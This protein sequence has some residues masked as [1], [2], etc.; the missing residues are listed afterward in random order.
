[1]IKELVKDEALLSQPGEVAT[2]DDLEVVQDLIDTMESLEDCAC[3]AAN[4]IGVNKRIVVV[5]VNEDGEKLALF[6]PKILKAAVP[7]KAYENC[8]SLERETKVTRYGKITVQF[9]EPV[10]GELVLRKR[11]FTDWVAEVIQHGIDHC[12]GKLV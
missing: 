11:E 8:F 4:M 10:D 5:E 3:I 12:K 6:N 2:I 7:W 9:Q 1:M